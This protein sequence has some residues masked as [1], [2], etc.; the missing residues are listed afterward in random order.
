[1]NDLFSNLDDLKISAQ[2]NILA[3]N[4][5]EELNE[6]KIKLLGKKSEINNYFKALKKIIDKEKKRT[7]GEKIN[8]LKFFIENLINEQAAKI[9]KREEKK[10]YESQKDMIDIT[11]PGK[12]NKFGA[13]HP[14]SLVLENIKDIFKR[15]GYDVVMAHS[16]ETVYYNFDALNI[17][18]NHPAR[19]QQDTFYIDSDRVL[20]TATS[21]MQVRVMENNKPPIKMISPGRVY[22]I[23]EVDATHLP[24]FHQVEGLVVDE[25]IK[26][27]D[28]KGTLSVFVKELI[29]NDVKMR[30][31]PHYFPFTEP[32]AEMDVT[33]FA[34]NGRGCNICKDSGF[35][36]LLGCGM[37]HPKVFELSKI[38]SNKFSGFAFGMGLERIAMLLYGINDIRLFYENDIRFLSQF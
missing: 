12:R 4:T 16:V 29:G 14:L 2:K 18:K 35:I 38:D 34:C 36:E 6:I 11:I 28:L 37:V 26:M 30:F 1:M 23:D 8:D 33:C 27:S 5:I 19:D 22:R 24:M 32:S 25:N 10:N 3:V 13:L 21:P 7:Y 31:R 15:M 20:V 9:C 17:P